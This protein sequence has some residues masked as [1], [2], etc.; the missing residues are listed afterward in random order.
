MTSEEQDR[1]LQFFSQTHDN[2]L[3]YGISVQGVFP[4]VDSPGV[5][6]GYTIGRASKGLAEF[7]ITGLGP[8]QLHGILN[9][10]HQRYPDSDPPTDEPIAEILADKYLVEFWP[11]RPD[12]DDYPLSVALAYEQIFG[13]AHEVRALQVMWQD[14]DHN[15]PWQDGWNKTLLQPLLRS[16]E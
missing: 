11:V 6:W 5:P 12:G 14:G 4:T 3:E 7:A 1:W 15:F 10:I 13:G 16:P 9:E 2:V 8:K